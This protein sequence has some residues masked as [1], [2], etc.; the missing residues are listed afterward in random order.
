LA[1]Y[2]VLFLNKSIQHCDIF[3]FQALGGQ[4]PDEEKNLFDCLTA[5]SDSGLSAGST[6]RKELNDFRK[7]KSDTNQ[8]DRCGTVEQ[9]ALVPSSTV[10]GNILVRG[11]IPNISSTTTTTKEND[12]KVLTKQNTTPSKLTS[13]SGSNTVIASEHSIGNVT[14]PS[15]QCGCTFV[16]VITAKQNTAIASVQIGSTIR[17][18]SVLPTSFADESHITVAA[19]SETFTGSAKQSKT[20]DAKITTDHLKATSKEGTDSLKDSSNT[21][22]EPV[23]QSD[24]VTDGKLS[25]PVACIS[26]YIGASDERQNHGHTDLQKVESEAFI[27]DMDTEMQCLSNSDMEQEFYISVVNKDLEHNLKLALMSVL[28]K[29]VGESAS[30]ILAPSVMRFFKKELSCMIQKLMVKALSSV[31]DNIT[32]LRNQGT[33]SQ[34]EGAAGVTGISTLVEEWKEELMLVTNSQMVEKEKEIAAPWVRAQKYR[35]RTSKLYCNNMAS[36][37]SYWEEDNDNGCN[38]RNIV[39]T[40]CNDGTENKNT[41]VG[42]AQYFIQSQ[43]VTDCKIMGI[44]RNISD[45]GTQTISTGCILYLKCLHDL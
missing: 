25:S 1:H 35:G 15:N 4:Q 31:I 23:N 44:P 6:I 38:S 43:N 2:L 9:N 21:A 40:D 22:S 27:S 36:T 24:Q 37:Q 20:E 33:V 42:S 41:L 34:C 18:M 5:E 10:S 11:S 17:N 3:Q 30:Q 8:L 29:E 26:E 13:P 28:K 39:G 7:N 19:A 14:A 45:K 32:E 16:P 12:C